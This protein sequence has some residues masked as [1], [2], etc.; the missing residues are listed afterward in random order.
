MVHLLW[1]HNCRWIS[2]ISQFIYR[3]YTSHDNYIRIVTPQ[4]ARK[5]LTLIE[6][7]A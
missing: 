3:D 6:L 5:A 4:A 2:T 7:A 1:Q